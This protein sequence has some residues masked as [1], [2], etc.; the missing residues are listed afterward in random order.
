MDKAGP[1]PHGFERNR[2]DPGPFQGGAR[3]GRAFPQVGSSRFWLS[4]FEDVDWGPFCPEGPPLSVKPGLAEARP[5]RR[6]KSY[7]SGGEGLA[8]RPTRE[9]PARDSANT[10]SCQRWF[11]SGRG[12][13]W[14]EI[15][16]VGRLGG[17]W[18][19]D[20]RF[21][22]RKGQVTVCRNFSPCV[23]DGV[24][25][26]ISVISRHREVLGGDSGEAR[27][28]RPGRSLG[29]RGRGG[30]RK[31]FGSPPEDP[32]SLPVALIACPRN[33]GGLPGGIRGARQGEGYAK[34]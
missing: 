10:G 9:G 34:R 33:G 2:L 3:K 13:G 17:T 28:G 18:G 22:S 15:T 11:N 7:P 19:A 30:V 27:G 20:E 31:R 8:R 1:N 14:R 6:A 24:E 21:R 29:V 26:P 32:A 4:S 23:V 12:S 25:L 16:E 5:V